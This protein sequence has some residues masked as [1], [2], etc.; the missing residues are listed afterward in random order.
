MYKWTTS[1]V[2]CKIL[3]SSSATIEVSLVGDTDPDPRAAYCR[4]C[5]IAGSD[6]ILN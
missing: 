4:L 1:D 2:G 6:E 3:L 5:G